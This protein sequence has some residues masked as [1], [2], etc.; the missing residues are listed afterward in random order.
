LLFQLFQL[1]A[2]VAD[3]AGHD[4]DVVFSVFAESVTHGYTWGRGLSAVLGEVG[5]LH[6]VIGDGHCWSVAG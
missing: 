3:Q 1:G 2:V 4:V 6:E 5:V